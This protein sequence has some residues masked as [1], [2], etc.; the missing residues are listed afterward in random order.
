MTKIQINSYKLAF[1]NSKILSLKD[2]INFESLTI[3]VNPWDIAEA[4]DFSLTSIKCS[5]TLEFMTTMEVDSCLTDWYK[6]LKIGGKLSLLVPNTDYFI[7]VNEKSKASAI[8]QG[9]T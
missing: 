3:Q 9:L 5:D 7:E 2:H 4:F 1:G 8:S 6:G